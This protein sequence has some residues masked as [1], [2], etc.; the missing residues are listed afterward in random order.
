MAAGLAEAATDERLAG[1]CHA[2][3][4]LV[5][6]AWVVALDDGDERP[7]VTVGSAPETGW[8][9]A[10][11]HRQPPPE[12]GRPGGRR[13]GR[14]GL[15]ATATSVDVTVAIGRAGRPFHTRER[16]QIA[17]LCRMA[18]ALLGRVPA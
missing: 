17:L 7:L 15:G 2:L 12:R 3:A 9:A 10:V 11:R 4:D 5:D 6:G 18:D 13:A 16:Q 8:L 1:L 14:P